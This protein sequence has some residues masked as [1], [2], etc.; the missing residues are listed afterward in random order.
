MK[1]PNINYR[2]KSL[3]PKNKVRTPD[4]IFNSRHAQ[5]HPNPFGLKGVKP[6][7][8]RFGASIR[9]DNIRYWLG[10]YDTAEE[11]HAAYNAKLEEMRSP[12]FK[13]RDPI[14]Y[15]KFNGKTRKRCNN[16]SG[17]TG[18]VWSNRW[19][20]YRAHI[21]HKN[22]DYHL[23]TFKT[24]EE[25]NAAYQAAFIKFKSEATQVKEMQSYAQSK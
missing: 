20:N 10:T 9:Q 16:T 14:D 17:Y 23:G 22:V 24:A 8:G 15:S 4:E 5:R 18:V 3:N 25:A 11:A 21:K 2:V 12:D 6:Q 7:R 1:I 19:K 13:H